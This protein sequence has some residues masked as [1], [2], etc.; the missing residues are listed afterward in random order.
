[1]AKRTKKQAEQKN[2]SRELLTRIRE[3]YK[4]MVEADQENRRRAMEDIKFATVPGWQWDPN[5]KKKRGRRPCYEFNKLRITCKRIIND[6]RA[7]R[8]S[9]KV[10]GVEDSDKKTAEILEGVIRNIWNNS[11][12]DTVID[13]AA[14]Y[15]VT[16]GYG[17]WRI[18]TK[19]AYD[20]AF[21][22]DICIEPLQNPFCL[23]W[24]PAAKDPLKRDAMDCILTDRIS[25]S[26]Y[27][28]RWPN[29]EVIDWEGTEF[30]DESDWQDE[31][32][33]RIVE[34]WYK[35]LVDKELW[36]LIDGKVI[37][38]ASD[39]AQL[40]DPATI[41]RKRQAKCY[42]VRMCIASGDAILEQSEWATD[43]L[44]F[45]P[46]YGEYL[47][48]DGKVQWHGIVR[49]ARDPQQA[50]N[51]SRTAMIETVAMT[52]QAKWWATVD[53]AKGHMDK[54]EAA[55][56]ENIPVMLYNSDQKAPGPPT[57]TQGAQVPSAL[58]QLSMLD[59]EDI[60][61]V[62]GIF[63]A[64][65]GQES[66]EKSGRAI[67]AR[68][69]QGE[70]ATFNYQD[71]MAKSIRRTWEMLVKLA[72]KIYDTERELRILGSDGAEDYARV[73]QVVFDPVTNKAIKVNDLAKGRYDV[74]ITVG[75]SFST[76]RQ[77]AAETY[78]QLANAAPQVM[79]V[80][81]DLVFK[82]MDLP[83]SEDIAERLKAMLPPPIQQ[84]LSQGKELPPEARAVMAQAAQ[85]MQ[86][87]EQKNQLVMQAAQEL[88]QEQQGLEKGKAEIQTA[89]A[90]LETKKA[91]FDAHIAKEMAKLTQAQAQL[92]VGDATLRANLAQARTQT[93]E[94]ANAGERE[95]LG[96]QVAQAL[97][98]INEMAQQFAV[99]AAQVLAQIQAAA[100]KP[101]P[102]LKAM[103]ARRV[104]GELI[105]E[106]I[107]EEE[108]AA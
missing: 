34:Y 107:Y 81:G 55:I 46:V 39:E 58:V 33:V 101:K 78:L 31:E 51:V 103:R 65:L 106:P 71:N 69:Q 99:A 70:I 74:T 8:P 25:R 57:P 27:E 3:R 61:A 35:E 79:A 37:D 95:Q 28:E 4:I 73:N 96:N 36:Q 22:Q 83:Y 86:L 42:R 60:K 41:A 77:E 45:V 49:W 85:A 91:Q 66:R 23:F 18:S 54:W 105:A 87:V 47:V 19:Y 80:A 15:Q 2:P 24:D 17:A 67:I 63:D 10:R 82:A 108:A 32:T 62:T 26:S 98:Q 90:Q 30:D 52:P 56:S 43:D 14:E 75:P 6:M 38:A 44:P 102:R 11:D 29:R 64:S 12:A 68:Q 100:N 53:Q 1:M 84:M 89:L 16:G 13:Y 97:A 21:E 92:Q 76:K 48:V 72:P 94:D 40:I 88:Q 50:Y 9:G 59:S 7:N 5:M 93:M 104:N 20:D